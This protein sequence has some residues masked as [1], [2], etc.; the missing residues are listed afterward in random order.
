M[1]G[2][3][4]KLEGV[5]AFDAAVHCAS[6]AA[7]ERTQNKARS[8]GSTPAGSGGGAPP[9]GAGS[10]GEPSEGAAPSQAAG[11][12]DEAGGATP[13]P[14]GTATHVGSTPAPLRPS[15]QQQQQAEDVD[16]HRAASSP[17]RQHA[18]APA[19]GTMPEPLAPA[20]PPGGPRAHGLGASAAA[21]LA[22]SACALASRP[23][24]PLQRLVAVDGQGFVSAGLGGLPPAG[25]HLNPHGQANVHAAPPNSTASLGHYSGASSPGA[26][27]SRTNSSGGSVG[28]LLSLATAGPGSAAA[29]PHH[30]SHQQPQPAAAAGAHVGLQDGSPMRGNPGRRMRRSSDDVAGGSGGPRAAGEEH[31]AA[32]AGSPTGTL[33]GRL[34]STLK[35]LFNCKSPR[36]S[37]GAHAR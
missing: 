15:P 10:Q 36:G 29:P 13:S 8:G 23:Q 2:Q 37:T 3:H 11:G 30:V 4:L 16:M 25:S 28:G 18:L 12:Q 21:A 9:E 34:R 7:A 5:G 24:L 33:T 22:S 35:T 6:V 20:T 14:S 32:A 26:S 17:H 27:S 19:P 31:A 1:S